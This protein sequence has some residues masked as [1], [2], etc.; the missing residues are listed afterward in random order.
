MWFN[1]DMEAP[2]R[3]PSQMKMGV[4]NSLRQKTQR[5]LTSRKKSNNI[6][7]Q[8]LRIKQRF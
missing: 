7:N 4:K 5:N 8:D 1:K 6:E 2:R 3:T